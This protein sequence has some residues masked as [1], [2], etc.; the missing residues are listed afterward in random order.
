MMRKSHRLPAVALIAALLPP[1]AAGA[2]GLQ[3]LGGDTVEV[4][5]QRSTPGAAAR[6]RGRCPAIWRGPRRRAA[7]RQWSS[8]TA[9]AASAPTRHLR[10]GH[11]LL[12]MLRASDRRA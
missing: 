1:T 8:C 7:I 5:A 3:W 4:A 6:A 10:S 9:A 12:R 2:F 11:H